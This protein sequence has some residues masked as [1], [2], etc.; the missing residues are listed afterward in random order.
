VSDYKLLAENRA[1][2]GRKPI[3]AM[4]DRIA[5]ARRLTTLFSVQRGFSFVRLGDG[6]AL[7]LLNTKNPRYAELL[8]SDSMVNGTSSM[9]NPGLDIAQA[10]RL[11]AALEQADYLDYH[12]FLWKDGTMLDLLALRRTPG[13][14]HNPNRETSYILPVWLEHEFKAYCQN[15]RVLFCGAEAP[16][17]E[18]LLKHSEFR[19]VAAG[20]WPEKCEAFFLRPRENG[21]NLARNLDLIKH[22]LAAA[23]SEW[24]IDTLFLSLGGGAKILCH[25]LALECGICAI[26]FGSFLRSLTYSG[27]VGHR[28][29]RS[30]HTVFLFR[31]PFGLY[32]AALEKAF[33]DLKP[34][35]LLAKAHA[36]LLLEVQEKEKGWS[37]SAWEYDFSR[38]NLASFNE[39]FKEYRSR[40]KY[41]F[42]ASP[43]TR[44]ERAGFLH[45]CGT[46]NLTDEGRW[47]LR[48]FKFKERV[49]GWLGL[50]KS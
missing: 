14:T 24:N 19:Q 22:D 15:R 3:Y 10:P 13:A 2:L 8:P 23:I 16:L 35:E 21:R 20:F 40:Y 28:A 49:R 5:E 36:Q 17:L 47:F 39:V 25:E 42:K 31:V 43:A 33:P 44:K 26:D 12:E 46:H 18:E 32:M 41:H 37:H 30:T 6:D 50:R 29:N 4:A 27:S 1:H 7:Y 48:R 34:E 38:E 9:Q 45:F 11:R